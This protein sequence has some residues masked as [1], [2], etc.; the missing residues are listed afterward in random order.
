MFCVQVVV[1][2]LVSLSRGQEIEGFNAD[3][4]QE[5][6]TVEKDSK[7]LFLLFYSK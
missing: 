5:E 3:A 1:V 7:F 6:A 4:F 2:L